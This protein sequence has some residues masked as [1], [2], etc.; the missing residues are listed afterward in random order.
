MTLGQAN[1]SALAA[2][3]AGDLNALDQALQARATAIASLRREAPSVPLAARMKE[4]L[5]AGES[6]SEALLALKQRA[7]IECARLAQLKS[8]F[9]AGLGFSRKTRFSYRG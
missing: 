2:T 1:E 4:A 8:G 7:G 3:E 5:K 9:T 6:I